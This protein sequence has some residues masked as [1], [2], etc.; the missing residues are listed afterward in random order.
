VPYL[1]TQYYD[2]HLVDALE[3][4]LELEELYLGVVGLGKTFF[5][6]LST[7]GPR[8]GELAL[9]FGYLYPQSRRQPQSLWYPIQPLGSRWRTRRNDAAPV[10]DD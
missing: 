7:L 8:R 4:L 9:P 1:D 6:V 5:G 2:Q 3:M 10:Q